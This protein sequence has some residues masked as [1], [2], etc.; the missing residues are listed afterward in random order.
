MA[1]KETTTKVMD[2]PEWLKR[3]TEVTD[4]K[5]EIGRRIYAF[6]HRELRRFGLTDSV[7]ANAVLSEVFIR[8]HTQIQRPEYTIHNLESWIISVSHRYIR[9]LSRQKK[10]FSSF[11][12]FETLQYSSEAED[13]S[14]YRHEDIQFLQAALAEIAP[15]ER[16]LLELKIIAGKSWEDIRSILLQE[17]YEDKTTVAWRKMKERSLI[18]L[19]REFHRIRSSKQASELSQQANLHVSKK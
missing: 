11:D 14:E 7:S 3:F 15:L 12:Q 17:G 2:L 13:D 1:G 19:R 18:S 16:R 6:I 5:T 4:P 9:E 10:R 8:G